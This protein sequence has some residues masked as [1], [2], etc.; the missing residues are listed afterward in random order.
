M[1]RFPI[2]L[3]FSVLFASL[4]I[5]ESVQTIRDFRV[6]EFDRDNRLRSKLFGEFARL[7]PSGL[8]DITGMRIDFFDDERNVEMRVLAETCIYD[9]SEGSARSDS[10][11]R[12][13]R[14]DLRIEGTGFEWEPQSGRFHI[15]ED[16]KVV[17]KE[18]RSARKLI[19]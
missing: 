19:E 8:I 18:L 3:L 10:A 13:M 4:A 6:P 17:F 14:Q 11:I 15:H 5:A 12:I 2:I 1:K 16:A 7:L 9:R